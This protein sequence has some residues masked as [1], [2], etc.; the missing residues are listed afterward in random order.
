MENCSKPELMTG[1]IL[2]RNKG[3][4]DSGDVGFGYTMPD[5]TTFLGKF[6]RKGVLLLETIAKTAID[7][8][9]ARNTSFSRKMKSAL[10]PD[11]NDVQQL[12]NCLRIEFRSSSFTLE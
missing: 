11:G 7:G 4:R 8:P 1:R 12:S 10:A 5:R 2:G 9:D 3:A 6:P